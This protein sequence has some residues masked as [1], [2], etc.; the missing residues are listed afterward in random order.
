MVE[1]KPPRGEEWL[2]VGLFLDEQRALDLF[3][4]EGKPRVVAHSD[5]FTSVTRR[6]ELG[7]HIRV[8]KFVPEKP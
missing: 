1:C 6:H 2:T 8:V 3:G 5:N 7:G 4:E